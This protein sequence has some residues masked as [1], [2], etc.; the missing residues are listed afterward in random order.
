MAVCILT[1]AR[2]AALPSSPPTAWRDSRVRR[3]WK[4]ATPPTTP[5]PAISV[6]AAFSLDPPWVWS[7]SFKRIG[8]FSC[9]E[10]VVTSPG[11]IP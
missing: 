11:E 4:A 3:W 2:A 8:R 1:P 7:Y 6:A 5:S 9:W 10:R